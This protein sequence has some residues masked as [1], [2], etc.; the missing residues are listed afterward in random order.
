MALN[1]SPLVPGFGPAQ[2]DLVLLG[3]APGLNETLYGKP[4]IGEAGDELTRMLSDAGL[5]RSSIYLTNVFKSR[6]PSN[7]IDLF[8]APRS[9]PDAEVDLPARAGRYL[10]SELREQYDS[11]LPELVRV[12]PRL[13]VALGSTAAWFL[14]GESKISSLVG[15]L[16][17]PTAKR[18]FSVLP[19]YHPSFVLRQWKYRTT[20]VANFIKA[21]EYLQTPIA[22][23]PANGMGKALFPNFKLKINPMLDEVLAWRDRLIL[24]PRIAVDIE[25][26]FGQIRTI[27]FADSP[28]TAICIPFW[29]PPKRSYWPDAES[30]AL[31]WAAVREILRSPGRKILH[32]SPYDIIYLYRGMGLSLGGVIEDTMLAAH[33]LEPEL[34]KGLGFLAATYLQNFPPWKQLND[35]SHEQDK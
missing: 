4:F 24:A 9:D 33:A 30:E 19:T 18:P 25:T 34:P 32:N 6:P 31:A 1:L 3:E 12:A 21:R 28:T 17:P 13:V 20:V 14:L 5:D 2:A 10:R 22:A 27:A 8:F 15:N 35:S 7:D 23:G 11:L 16:Y 26:A 29:E